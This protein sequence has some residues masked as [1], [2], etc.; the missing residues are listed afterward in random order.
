MEN[1]DRRLVLGLG[2]A[3]STLVLPTAAAAQTYGPD[4]GKELAPGVRQVDL[5]E[6]ESVIPAYK[7]VKMRDIVIQ[8]GAKTTDNV[9]KNDMVCHLLEGELSVVQNKKEFTVKKGDVWTCAN[10]DTAEGTNNKSDAVAI[11]RVTDLMIS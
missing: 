11:M 8:P 4:E 10:T 1:M 5:S 6:R 7:M 2:L 3:A 9:M